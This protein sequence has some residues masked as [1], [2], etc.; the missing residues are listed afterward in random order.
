[1]HQ[2]VVL[3][4][5][6]FSVPDLKRFLQG[7]DKRGFHTSQPC[8]VVNKYG[9]VK[10]RDCRSATRQLMLLCTSYTSVIYTK[11]EAAASA[12]A[13]VLLSNNTVQ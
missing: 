5:T 4:M 9:F 11:V 7:Q 2:S 1:M 8:S 10:L 13:V 12:L 3:S 6:I